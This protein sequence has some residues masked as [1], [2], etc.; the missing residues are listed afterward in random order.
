MRK[1]RNEDLGRKSADEFRLAD[2]SPIVVVLDNVRSLNN[3]GSVFRTADAFLCKAIYLC[4]ITAQPPHREI[5]KTALGAE[6]TVEWKYFEKTSI[7][8][9]ELKKNR[10]KI[11]SIEQA[12]GG[13]S[14]NEFIFNQSEKY[15]LIFGHEV[16]GVSED[17]LGLS[18]IALEIPQHGTKHSLNISVAAGIVIWEFWK[19][20]KAK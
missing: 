6:L 5:H 1:I 18:D 16:E 10:Y 4:G 17:V 19:A 9:M 12:E 8:V 14:L 15:A 13:L 2:K 11:I 7:A 20:L 3:I